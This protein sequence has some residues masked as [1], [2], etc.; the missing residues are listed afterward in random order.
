ME[1]LP[2]VNHR[3]ELLYNEHTGVYVLDDSFN[4]NIEGV[5]TTVDLLKNTLFQGKRIYLTPGL[6][7]L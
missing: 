6:V 3:L 1:Q 4:G 7:E 5:K 2:F